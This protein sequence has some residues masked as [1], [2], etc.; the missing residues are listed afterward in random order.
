MPKQKEKQV[1]IILSQTGTILSRIL[2]KITGAKYNHASI[3]LDADLH[4]MYSF[5]RKNPYNPFFGGFVAE[6]PRRGTFG[7]FRGTDAVVLSIP[8]ETGKFHEMQAYLKKMKKN[9]KKYH[10]NYLGL[11][12]AY[13]HICYKQKNHYYCSEFVRDTLTRFQVADKEDFEP[14]TPPISF[15]NLQNCKKIYIGK[16]RAFTPKRLAS[17]K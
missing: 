10:Y 14:I 11:I 16:L 17:E 1:Y 9:K 4:T 15:L 5:G 6:S 12:L 8:I 2:K 13:F 3:S 7:R